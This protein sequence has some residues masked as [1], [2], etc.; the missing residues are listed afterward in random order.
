MDDMYGE[1]KA[2]CYSLG[3]LSKE[4]VTGGG[5]KKV[6]NDQVTGRPACHTR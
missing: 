5:A 4:T 6:G 1:I 2:I 3:T